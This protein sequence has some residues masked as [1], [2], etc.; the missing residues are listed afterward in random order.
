[1]AI[2]Q[3]M[4]SLGG[5]LLGMGNGGVSLARAVANVQWH[6]LSIQEDGDTSIGRQTACCNTL[7]GECAWHM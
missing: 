7:L 1:M 2:C 4:I 5:G 6:H 3:R